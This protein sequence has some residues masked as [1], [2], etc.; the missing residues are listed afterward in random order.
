MN[1]IRKP[2]THVYA[3]PVLLGRFVRHCGSRSAVELV[4]D[5]RVAGRHVGATSVW[6]PLRQICRPSG[7]KKTFIA[8]MRDGR[9]KRQG[10]G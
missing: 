1:F 6:V 9:C 2:N 10:R 4:S 3:K 8:K 5:M 7:G